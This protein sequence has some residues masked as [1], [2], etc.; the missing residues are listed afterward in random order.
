LIQRPLRS[1]K[2]LDVGHDDVRALGVVDVRVGVQ[3]RPKRPLAEIGQHAGAAVE[4]GGVGR[5]DGSG[6]LVADRQVRRDHQHAPARDTQRQDRDQ[7]GLA[8]PDRDLLDR[9]VPAAGEILDRRG[10]PLGLRVTQRPVALDAR[11]RRLEETVRCPRSTELHR[12][13][14]DHC[15]GAGLDGS[16]CERR[17]GRHA[18]A[19]LSARITV[20]HLRKTIAWEVPAV[21]TRWLWP[22]RRSGWR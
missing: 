18:S 10:V 1:P 11:L 3:H 22:V 21:V 2:L 8:A 15:G 12:N 19:H 20:L 17:V 16:R 13:G 5:V 7:P 6:D 14:H 4:A 9:A